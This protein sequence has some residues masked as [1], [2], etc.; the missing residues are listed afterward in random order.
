PAEFSGSG[1]EVGA[2]TRACVR[3]A[4]RAS[5]RVHYADSDV[6][7]PESVADAAYG[8]STDDRAEVFRPGLELGADDDRVATE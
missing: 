6:S 2:A 3:D 5:L 8:V 4:I 1:T 7:L